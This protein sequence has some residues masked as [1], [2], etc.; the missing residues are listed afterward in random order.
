MIKR[1]YSCLLSLFRRHNVIPTSPSTIDL[2]LGLIQSYPNYLLY[3]FEIFIRHKERYYVV[4]STGYILQLM[5][6]KILEDYESC[7]IVKVYNVSKGELPYTN[8]L[9]KLDEVHTIDLNHYF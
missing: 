2:I 1:I 3:L 4:R 6:C 5:L 8:N 9:L 7:T